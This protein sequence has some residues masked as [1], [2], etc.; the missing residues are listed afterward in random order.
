MHLP[1]TVKYKPK[2]LTEV[3]GNEDA[4]RKVLE[5]IKSW[6][7]NIPKKRALFIYGPPG[8]GK[9]AAVEALA[10]DLNMELVQSNA[11]DYRTAEDVERFV[12]RAAQLGTLFGKRRLILFDEI[13]GISGTEDR[14]GLHLI[15]QI[16]NKTSSPIIVIANNAYDQRFATLRN[17]TE[18]VEFKKPA[19]TEI[20]KHLKR[21][22]NLEGIEADASAIRFI[23]ERA[24]GDVRSAVNDLQAL[25]QGWRTLTYDDV[26][27]LAPRDRKDVIFNVLRNILYAKDVITA[28]RAVDMA[29]VDPDML[30][31]WVYENIP[32]HIKDPKELSSAMNMMA[33]A[34]IYRNRIRATQN[35][36][37]MRYYLDFM[38]AGVSVAWSKKASGWVPFKFPTRISQM[39]SSKVD[40]TMLAEIGMKIRRR[41]HI[42]AARA[43]KEV[44]PFLRIIFKN[45]PKMGKEIA[46]W[47]GLSEEMINYIAG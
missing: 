40:R 13:D 27:W 19:R 7:R 14:G 18:L 2:T 29:D 37:L 36:S 4:K 20:E 9:T 15:T 11:S 33:L 6:E 44:L 45:N 25:A 21:I 22:C 28:K 43:I 16:I 38:T 17:M 35:W 23:A 34:D 26:S 10:N 3:I 32:Y 46:N 24:D 8:V 31:E 5:W 12:G 30:F 39:S 42:S 47:L 41:C 1:W